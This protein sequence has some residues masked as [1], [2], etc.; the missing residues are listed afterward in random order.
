M[1]VTSAPMCDRYVLPDQFAAEREF[2]TGKLAKA[3]EGGEVEVRG[4]N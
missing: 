4:Y 1:V 2:L 3:G